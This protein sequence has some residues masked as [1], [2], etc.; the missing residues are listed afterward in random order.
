[1]N[2]LHARLDVF[3]ELVAAYSYWRSSAYAWHNYCV[4]HV[5][6]HGNIADAVFELE[7]FH[8]FAR[9]LQNKRQVVG[10]LVGSNWNNTRKV[11]CAVLVQ[12]HVGCATTDVDDHSP[13]FFFIVRKNSLRAYKDVEGYFLYAETGAV[14]ALQNVLCG[15]H[16]TC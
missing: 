12:H 3:S 1:E 14:H 8:L 13:K 5:L 4:D 7:F 15:C 10:N 2:F 6:S 16:R 11:R 9:G